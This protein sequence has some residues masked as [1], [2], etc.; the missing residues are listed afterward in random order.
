MAHADKS[1]KTSCN[2]S[3]PRQD[4][5]GHPGGWQRCQGRDPLQAELPPPPSPQS[6]RSREEAQS[7]GAEQ[8]RGPRAGVPSRQARPSVIPAWE[9]SSVTGGPHNTTWTH[10]SQQTLP[11]SCQGVAGSGRAVPGGAKPSRTC[12]LLSCRRGR[13]EGGRWADRRMFAFSARH[14]FQLSR[15]SAHTAATCRRTGPWKPLQLLLTR[16]R[17]QLQGGGP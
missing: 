12:R 15:C 14:A 3:E 17:T 9:R 5:L 11:P 13:D 10:A 4:T 6:C 16:I 7:R 2:L 8:R 1:Q